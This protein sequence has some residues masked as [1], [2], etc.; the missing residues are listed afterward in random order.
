MVITEKQILYCNLWILSLRSFSKLVF[1]LFLSL[2]ATSKE[3]VFN[4]CNK[5]DADV[6]FLHSIIM[7]VFKIIVRLAIVTSD[8][9][10]CTRISSQKVFLFVLITDV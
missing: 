2:F 7:F 5:S 1:K 6:I 3:I 10:F 9:I 4:V 8:G